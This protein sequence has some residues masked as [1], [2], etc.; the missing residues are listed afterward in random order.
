[1]STNIPCSRPGDPTWEIT[2][3]FPN[4]GEWT[5]GDYLGL[6][7]NRQ[8]ELNNGN[9]ELLPVP[10]ELHQLIAFYL[11]TALRNLGNENP[12][13]IAL[14]SPFRVRVSPTKF[15]EPDVM[16]MLNEHRDRR[17]ERY[18]D[19]ADLVMEVVSEDDPQRDLETKRIEYAQAK[20]KEYW[21]VDPR[22]RTITVL[23]MDEN[24]GQYSESGHYS[25]GQLA[26]SV[27]LGGLRVDVSTVFNQR[28]SA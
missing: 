14:L 25:D 9:L 17:S 24:S 16:F 19:G 4:Q 12:P 23:A 22:D 13:G 15:R 20:I 27:L 18:W 8:V 11:C 21:I 3:L 6:T 2:A 10:T 26:I 7:T 28:Q 5:A 1:M